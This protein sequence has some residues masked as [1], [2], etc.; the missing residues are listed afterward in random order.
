[1][2]RRGTP[3]LAEVRGPYVP[4]GALVPGIHKAALGVSSASVLPL[5]HPVARRRHHFRHSAAQRGAAAP[6]RTLAQQPMAAR[7]G[8]SARPPAARGRCRGRRPAE[9]PLP[10]AD[11][12]CERAPGPAAVSAPRRRVPPPRP[13]AAPRRLLV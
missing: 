8:A 4:P 13:T 1:M 5:A 6:G 3:G 9:A 7:P 2:R 12:N 10:V 11:H